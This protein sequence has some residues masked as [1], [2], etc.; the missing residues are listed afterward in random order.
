MTI[1]TWTADDYARILDD[2]IKT[3][4]ARTEAFYPVDATTAS[5]PEQ[6]QMYD[7]LSED[8]R[9]DDLPQ[10]ETRDE[11]IPNE[12]GDIPIRRYMPSGW[13]NA[14]AQILFF[15][16][17]GYVLGSLESHHDLCLQVADATGMLLTAVDYALSPERP[18]PQD[19]HDAMAAFEHVTRDDLPIITF[20]DSAGANLAAAVC[21]EKRNHPKAPVGQVLVY[22]G[23]GSDLTRGSFVEHANAP[24][25]STADTRAYKSMRAG[26]DISRLAN[27]K[28]SPLEDE[29]FSNL[30]Q[31]TV[32]SA[33]CDPLRDDGKVYCERINA[34]GGQATYIEEASLIHGYL[35]ARHAGGKA[36]QSFVHICD[37][38][39]SIAEKSSG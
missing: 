32:F 31:T 13:Q 4:I 21:H 37:A 19:W 27:A 24:G 25:L 11:V 2:D 38:L 33:Q 10:I 23:L 16:G 36:A 5:I 28:A 34:A 12:R 14:G 18:F 8:F 20:G 3:F 7:A 1:R 22:P 29:D 26:G 6:R 9:P 39:R 15:H 17:G 35:R 30:S